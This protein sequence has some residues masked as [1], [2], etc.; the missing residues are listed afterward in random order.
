MIA[1]PRKMGALKPALA[2]VMLLAPLLTPT[3]AQAAKPGDLDRSFGHNGKVK[4]V[5]DCRCKANSLTIDSRGRI[6]AV[7]GEHDWHSDFA[8]ARYGQDGE[9]DRSFSGDGRVTTDL[10]G[11]TDIARSVAIDSHGRIVAAGYWCRG[12]G[13][14]PTAWAWRGTS[15]TAALT[16][17]SVGVA[18]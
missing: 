6:V 17:P 11:P 18:G 1:V 5:F 4:T 10:F 9:L 13:A 7:G 15:A 14:G 2:F 8:V 3:L 12:S 16:A